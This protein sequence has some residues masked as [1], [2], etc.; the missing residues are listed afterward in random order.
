MS[1]VKPGRRGR[2]RRPN[3]DVVLD[4]H[5][6]EQNFYL[7]QDWTVIAVGSAVDVIPPIGPPYAGFV[8]AKTSDSTI[9]WV[10]SVGGDGRRMHGNGE[11]V[12]LRLQGG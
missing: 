5:E 1:S 11:G 12:C 6:E 9:L 10:I 3:R 7:E 2:V 8:D 4:H